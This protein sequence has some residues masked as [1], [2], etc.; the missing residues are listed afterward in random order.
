M[1][2]A[3]RSSYQTETRRKSSW[4][5]LATFNFGWALVLTGESEEAVAPLVRAVALAPRDEQWMIAADA[6]AVL[7][8]TYLA[9]DLAQAERW[10]GE[11]FEL[12]R[13]HGLV[14]L[15]HIGYYHVILGSLHARRGERELADHTLGLG[16]E[17][18]RQWD[19]LLIAEALLER[20]L[21]RSGVGART[22]ARAMLG[23]ARALIE[24]CADP[25]M[26]LSQRLEEV[27]RKL[28]PARVRANPDSELT[29]RELEVLRLLAEGLTKR[30]VAATLF[31][32]Y[33]TIHS[34]TKSIYRKLGGSSRD[35]VLER[36]R[37]Q[38]LI[39]SG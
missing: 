4:E 13:T 10:I 9:S 36:A 32:S 6:R 8:K 30:E 38:G 16:L 19:T 2:A 22:E 23:E 35:E 31:L 7:A 33:S 3:A 25:G 11:A 12:A 34:H 15:P 1:L 26:M 17:Q 21:V 18:M 29:E 37:G 24:S 20:A 39:A 5:S 28:T 14:D 27:A